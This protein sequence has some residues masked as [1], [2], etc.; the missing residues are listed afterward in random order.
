MMSLSANLWFNPTRWL[1]NLLE[2]PVSLVSVIFAENPLSMCSA[3]SL[4]SE[5][6]LSTIG[7]GCFGLPGSFMYMRITLI[8][9]NIIS[10]RF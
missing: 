5:P 2:G 6:C 10:L 7:L 9:R 1:G 4:T 8:S 3:T